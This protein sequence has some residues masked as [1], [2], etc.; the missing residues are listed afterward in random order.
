MHYRSF[1][2]RVTVMKFWRMVM[3]LA[4]GVGACLGPALA[5]AAADT[6]ISVQ[7]Y[8]QN[9]AADAVTILWQTTQP[10]YG[11]VEYGLT[12]QLGLMQDWVI[13]G[14]RNANTTAHRVRLSGLEAGK[15]Y[16]YRIGYKPIESF[17]P[18]KVVFGEQ[19]YTPIQQFTLPAA[20]KAQVTCC[21]LNDLHNNYPLYERLSVQVRAL[22]PDAVFF[23]GDCFADTPSQDVALR[24]L[25]TYTAGCDA[26]SR[27]TFFIRGNHEIRGAYARQLGQLFEYPEGKSYF[28]WSFGPVRFIVL[29]CGEDKEDAHVEYSGLNDFRKFREEQAQWL[30]QEINS[31][32]FKQA[33]Y[34]ILVHHMPLYLPDPTRPNLAR[35]LWEPVLA[36]APIDLAISAH[37]H[38]NNIVATHAMGNPYPLVIGGGSDETYAT[39]IV[40]QADAQSCRISIR[41]VNGK[42]LKAITIP[43][44]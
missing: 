18:Y 17:G 19:R 36:T 4:L 28:A 6:G 31:A 24:A 7:P 30:R 41:D 26:A 13:D 42:E 8:L 27:P 14:L 44:R 34:R 9:P 35:A 20:N 43:K 32:S 11:W 16:Y 2:P 39:L 15:T 10:A 25:R 38:R 21:F 23:N 12:E 40:L 1:L 33:T 22:A 37:T 29:D 3:C 5:Q